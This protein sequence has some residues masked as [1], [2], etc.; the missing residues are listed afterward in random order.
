MKYSAVSDYFDLIR[1]PIL[2]DSAETVEK[3]RIAVLADFATQQLIAL[4]K[5]LFAQD[6]IAA[7]IYEAPFDSITP[8]IMNADS[9]LY[10][11]A[12]QFV[13]ILHSTQTLQNQ[14]C[15]ST[16][17]EVF[18]DGRVAHVKMLWEKLR[19][20]SNA[21]IVQGNFAPP[22]GRAFGH[23]ELKVSDSI[24]AIV[25][26]INYRI[27][28]ESRNAKNVLLADVNHLASDIGLKEFFD[29]RLWNIAKT[30]CRV[31]VLPRLAQALVDIVLTANGRFVKCVVLDLDNT[32]WG[33]VIGDDGLD[34]IILGNFDEGEAFVAFQKF[35]L[36][37]KRRGIILAVV[38]KND[39]AN[40]ILPFREHPSMI[41]KES[42]ISV[43][44]ANWD[45]KADNIRQVQQFLNIGFDSIVFIDDNPFERNIVRKYLPD[46][47]V[48]EMPEDPSDYVRALAELNL[49]ETAS[50]SEAD[51]SRPDQYRSEAL[52]RQ[53]EVSYAN[54]SDY[55]RSLEMKIKLERFNSFNLPRIAQLG[56]RSNQFNLTT[57]R[58]SEADYE[59][60][61]HDSG[62]VPFTIT[63]SDKCGDYGLI[64]I[65]ILNLLSDEIEI[66]EYLMSCRVLQRGVEDY[67]MHSIFEI[68]TK[69]GKSRV[70]G[71]YLKT[72]KNDMVKNFYGRFGFEKTAEAES[73]DTVWMLATAAFQPAETFMNTTINELACEAR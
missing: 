62:R 20:H 47:I 49:F 13:L 18:A 56:Q 34:G 65:I 22:V 37:L 3:L 30:P 67:A 31:Q 42:D 12:P 64:S 46:V 50:Y 38:S 7:E 5:T 43:F 11:F 57:R 53:T 25:A 48:P 8:E 54:Y 21:T 29:E 4:L 71:R 40:A 60:I 28:L 26:D 1:K 55:L 33:G 27:A 15:E 6:K 58:Y 19:V 51:R 35:I 14:I 24:A 9:D 72:A 66:D 32:L 69:L 23:Y 61:A 41:L 52:R 36:E 44:V 73:G 45:N 59:K 68:A 63:L 2:L 16:S 10:Q 70:V 17:R 39:H